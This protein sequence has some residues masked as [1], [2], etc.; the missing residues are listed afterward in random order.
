MTPTDL[1]ARARQLGHSDAELARRIGVHR[2]YLS[3]V[4]LGQV[5]LSP[6][7]AILLAD[8][9]GVDPHD[10]L[11]GTIVANQRD[12][13]KAERLKKALFVCWVLGVALTFHPD[14]AAASTEQASSFAGQNTH[15]AQWLT[16]M[17]HALIRW[18][19]LDKEHLALTVPP[20]I[21]NAALAG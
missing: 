6:E 18:L 21:R 3:Q 20:G 12:P 13:E 4:S 16:Q 11:I 10:A 15:R 19:G 1:L 14:D 8:I 5:K 9:A 7:A 17:L 2:S